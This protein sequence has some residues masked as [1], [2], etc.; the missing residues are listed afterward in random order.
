MPQKNQFNAIKNYMIL[1]SHHNNLNMAC[2]NYYD[3][4]KKLNSSYFMFKKICSKRSDM[5]LSI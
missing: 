5:I 1:Q 4:I 2:Q 3:E